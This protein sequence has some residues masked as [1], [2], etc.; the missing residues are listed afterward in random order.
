MKFKA[1]KSLGQNFL[2]DE[3]ARNRIAEA[4]GIAEGDVVIEIGPGTGLLTKEL[5]KRPLRKLIAYEVDAGAIDLLRTEIQDE[6]FD[7]RG[8]DF[9]KADLLALSSEFGSRLK[10]IGNI[11]YYITSPIIFKL[12]DDRQVIRDA[13]L[14]IQ[15]E[16]AERLVANPR[17]KEYGIPT[18]LA[19]FFG[20]VKFCFKVKAGCFR[21][22]PNV[23]SALIKIDFLRDYLSRSGTREPDGFEAKTFQRF[24]RTMFAMRRKMLRNN[25]KSYL[26]TGDFGKAVEDVAIE[27]YLS[28]RAEE[29][30]VEEF[31]RFFMA[32]EKWVK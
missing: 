9:L 31:L 13:T 10:V 6:R 23:D 1:N 19:N 25:L 16:V 29:L 5:L 12:I 7:L 20:E 28:Q 27:R 21:P 11:P 18:V 2:V 4:A 14:L 26:S 30:D 15:L 22:V 32:V 17:T 3:K 8:E 24:V